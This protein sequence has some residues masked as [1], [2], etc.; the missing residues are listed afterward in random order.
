VRVPWAR[1]QEP[2]DPIDGRASQYRVA[3][4][5]AREPR[6]SVK[7]AGILGQLGQVDGA[8]AI[9][10]WAGEIWHYQVTAV[11][12]GARP[13]WSE[14]KRFPLFQFVEELRPSV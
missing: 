5:R 3:R 2:A 12:R 7:I 9:S 11:R 4:T 13:N 10:G 1:R 14:R 6:M 8:Q